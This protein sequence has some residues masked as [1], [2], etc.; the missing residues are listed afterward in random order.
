MK[1]FVKLICTALL[2]LML[3]VSFASCSDSDIPDGYQLIACEGDE[4]RLYVPTQWIVNTSG[5]VTSAYYTSEADTSVSVYKADDADGLTL[6]EY[7]KKCNERYKTEL[8]SYAFDGK[9]EKIVLGGKL[10]QKYIFSAKM[11]RFNDLENKNVT[12][13]YK[14]LQAMAQ[15]DG[16]TFVLMFSA[17]TERFESLLEL[18]EGNSADEGIIPYFR[19]AE[20][21]T[22]EDNKKEFDSKVEAP[23]GMKLAS[24]N[25]RPYRFFVPTSW[26]INNRTDATA[27][28]ASD[29]DTS[30]VN[31]QM[32]MTSRNTETVSDHWKRLE[33]SYKTTFSSYTLI[34]DEEILMD[35]IK[36]HKYTYTVTSGGVEYRLVQ[37][38]VR[39]GEMF[40]YVTY[41]ALPE[42]F[43]K[44]LPDVEKM[45]ESFDIR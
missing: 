7:W 32:Y 25:E 41:T 9:S 3:V 33:E 27:A 43:E 5:G 6:D 35:G 36:A 42:N 34:S 45:I 23:K 17:T 8:S 16:K 20:P 39:K 44:H 29:S 31:V 14:F 24:T 4:F 15:N 38:I 21:Y 37:A 1:K 10:G 12:K 11:T 30:N 28:Y 22:S 40:Y 19:F 26:K 18:V 13:E 2:A